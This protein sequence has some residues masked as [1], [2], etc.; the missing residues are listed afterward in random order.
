MSQV[1]LNK[2]GPSLHYKARKIALVGLLLGIVAITFVFMQKA[3]YTSSLSTRPFNI[4]VT[5]A[6][7]NLEPALLDNH[8]QRLV[9]GAI[10]EGL[11]AYDETSRSIQPRLA[12]SLKY[13]KDGQNLVIHLRKDVKFSNGK[14]LNAHDV[15]ASW[16][17]NFSATREWSNISL[18]LPIVGCEDKLNGKSAEISGIKVMNEYSLRILL[19]K[20]HAAFITSLSNPIFWVMD[21][22]AGLTPPPGTGPYMLKE[23]TPQSLILLKNDH[24]YRGQPHLS[25]LNV[26]VFPDAAA[27]YKAYQEGKVDFLNAVPAQ[28]LAKVRKDQQYKGLLLEKPVLETYSLGFNLG[29]EPYA[30]SYLLRRALNYAIDREY[31]IKNILGGSYLSAKGLI[32]SGMEAYNQ[33]MYGYRYKPEKARDLLEE[34]GYPQGQGLRPLTLTYNKDDGHQQVA[35]EIARQLA[36]I[37][38]TVQLQ[39]QDWDYYKKQV[40]SRSMSFFRLGW[41]ADYPDADNFLYN[42]FHS[43]KIGV[44]NYCGY[45]NPQVDKILDASRAQYKDPQARIK[46]LR[47]AEEIIVDDAPCLWLFQK[48]AEKMISRD[49]RNLKLDRMEMVD[50]YQVE[51]TKPEIDK[52]PTPAEK[53]PAANSPKKQD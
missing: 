45:H 51:L 7:D 39:E 19:K 10:Y 20:P 47:R 23:K 36:Q 49:V 35:A 4:A 31:I 18:F 13:D 29:R 14:K 5:S 24:Y 38:I 32:P 52:S 1:G 15:K 21:L 16:E 11:A 30:G 33:G 46:L 50:W 17:K 48:K 44:S 8:G 53:A 26:T 28:E 43:S 27:A 34:A 2:E 40:N 12:K 9:A 22:S 42:L 25:A 37:G 41:A 3:I 6:M